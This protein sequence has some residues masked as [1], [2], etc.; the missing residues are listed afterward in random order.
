MKKLRSH[1]LRALRMLLL[2][3]LGLG[4]LLY[5]LQ[6]TLIF[7]AD[8]TMTTDPGARGWAFED[9]HLPVEGYETHGWYIPL[10]KHRGVVLF[11]HGNAGN[12]SYRLEH[13][14]LLRSF[15]FSV[16]AY[17]YGGFGHSTGTPTEARCYADIAAMWD[18]LVT[19][20]GIPP[21]DILLYGRSLGGGPT[22]E[23]ATRVKPGAVVL[24]STF[25]STADVAWD[26][27]VY[28]PWIWLLSHRFDS[29]QKMGDIHAPL[30]I[31]H[32]PQD[33]V[34]PFAHGAAL[35]R[36]ANAPKTFVTIQG[37]HNNGYA[38]APKVY[39]SA[40]EYFLTPIFGPNPG[41]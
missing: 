39:E 29:A 20:R 18:Y 3:Y 34:I 2:I 14:A 37:G 33:E 13:I 31:L 25:L 6:G 23:L 7:G 5:F 16:L 12:L 30:L 1:V 32:S 19:T 4:A 24:E 11:S 28:R 35:Y 21:R 27:P 40:W 15:G 9:L 22:T 36:R 26:M 10:E 8:P 38:T 41:S 17:D